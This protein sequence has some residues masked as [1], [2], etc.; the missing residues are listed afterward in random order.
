MLGME[1]LKISEQAKSETKSM[2]IQKAQSTEEN[3]LNMPFN[4]K[5]ELKKARSGN[6]EVSKI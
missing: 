1:Q 3:S 4:Q 6:E 5:E 2:I